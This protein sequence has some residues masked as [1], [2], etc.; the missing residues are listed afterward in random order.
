MLA[1]AELILLA[2][3]DPTGLLT[4]LGAMGF[5]NTAE[6]FLAKNSRENEVE[7]DATGADDRGSRVLRRAA[8]HAFHAQAQRGDGLAADVVVGDA[9]R[10]P[11][12]TAP[13]CGGVRGRCPTRAAG[14]TAPPWGRR[15]CARASTIAH[16]YAE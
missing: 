2:F 3:L 6:L 10:R 12:R 8:R 16:W 14:R 5:Q 11:R 15:F 4:L 13:T 9:S 7:A 1:Y